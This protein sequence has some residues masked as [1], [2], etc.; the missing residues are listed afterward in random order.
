[1]KRIVLIALL[2]ISAF[3]LLAQDFKVVGYLPYYRFSLVNQMDFSKLTHLNLAFANPDMEGNLDLGGQDIDPIVEMAHSYDLTVSLSLAGGALTAEWASAWEELIKEE[4]RS[5]FIHKIMEYVEE[6]DLDGLDVDLEWS[7]V[8][9]DYSGFVLELRDTVDV[10]GI[11][12]T[13]ALPG[14]YRYPEIS[15]AA[16]AAYDYINMMVYD[17][18]G[19]WAPNNPGPH[20]PYSFAVNA[21]AYWYLQQGVPRD[22]LTLGV[23][24]YGV[25]FAGSGVTSFTYRSMV[26]QD[27][28]YAYLDQ[29]GEAYYNG[30]PT[31]QAKTELALGQLSGIMIWELGQDAFNEYSLL[32]AID[33]VINPSTN[34]ED[35]AELRGVNAFP[36]PFADQ[37]NLRNESARE[38][39]WYLMDINGRMVQQGQVPGYASA[40]ILTTGLQSGFYTLQCQGEA[41]KKHFK[42]IKR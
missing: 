5:A 19:S 36:N 37:V 26:E 9:D 1:M 39:D 16:L 18:T 11:E 27:P 22:K 21:I 13:A 29:V 10:Y 17:L 6:H 34:T 38:L 7:H 12:L 4:N 40:M 15:D 31:I 14:T 33:E 35:I 32:N 42:L 24:F 30:I 25:D 8:N 41:G 3:Q 23:P 2:C 28:E 20:S